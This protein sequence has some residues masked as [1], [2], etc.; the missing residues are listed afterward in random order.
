MMQSDLKHFIEMVI[1]RA[2]WGIVYLS[3]VDKY[4][5]PFEIVLEAK[6]K[7]STIVCGPSGTFILF[8]AQRYYHRGSPP[9][10]N[11]RYALDLVFIPCRSDKTSFVMHQSQNSWPVDPYGFDISSFN[12]WPVLQ[13]QS[14]SLG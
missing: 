12:S 8:D 6:T 9:L 7:R 1:H 4:S 2:Y 10:N 5:G 13:E 14:I 3:D 11:T